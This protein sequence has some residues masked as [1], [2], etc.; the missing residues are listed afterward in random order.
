MAL[1]SVLGASFDK[2]CTMA[3]NTKESRAHTPYV[4]KE[5]TSS[6]ISDGRYIN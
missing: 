1:M 3:Q 6:W 4:T 5:E 2:G